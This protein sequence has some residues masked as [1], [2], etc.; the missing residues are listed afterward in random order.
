[1]RSRLWSFGKTSR[2]PLH[3]SSRPARALGR[4]GRS[5]PSSLK[6]ATGFVGLDGAHGRA[7]GMLFSQRLLARYPRRPYACARA[8]TCVREAS[9]VLTELC[10][11]GEGRAV[12]L[13]DGPIRRSMAPLVRAPRRSC[14]AAARSRCVL[15][16]LG[17]R[18]RHRGALPGP[19]LGATAIASPHGGLRAD[20]ARKHLRTNAHQPADCFKAVL[21]CPPSTL[22]EFQPW[23]SLASATR[24]SSALQSVRSG[25]L[26]PSWGSAA[27]TGPAVLPCS[28]PR[29][30]KR[31]GRS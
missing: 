13:K 19:W 21:H 4:R 17:P 29:A 11:P 22:S 26:E 14:G 24:A 12:A 2:A 25:S 7:G 8:I 6:A 30:R 15:Y 18:A 20:G 16:H 10:R 31:A 23:P 9:R 28:A 1:M 5:G 27:R 3:A